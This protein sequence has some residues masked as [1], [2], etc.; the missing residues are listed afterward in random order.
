MRTVTTRRRA[1]SVVAFT[2]MA[3]GAATMVVPFL[4]MVST[5]LKDKSVVFRYPPQWIPSPAQ[6]QNFVDIWS[7]MPL[8]RGLANSVIV[9]GSVVVIGLFTSTLAAFA[10]ATLDL[11]HKELLFTVVL[12]IMM[13]PAITVIIPQFLLYSEIG[14]IDTLWPLIVP[15]ALG[16]AAMI[17]FLRQFI[18][19]LPSELMDAARVDGASVPRTYWTIYLPLLKPAMAAYVIIV[20]MWTWNQYLEPL[21]FT[22]SPNKQT[23]Q[24]A[25]AAL[26]SYYREQTNFPIVMAASVIA[27]LP[28]IIMFVI[29]QRY[30]IDS[31]AIS[32][33]KG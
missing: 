4:W 32:G 19:G 30:F 14:W 10:F 12:I 6:W 20:F 27:I 23:V 17:F 11:P 31:F 13:F 18:A 28:V 33:F 29:L 24:L 15:G 21:I 3:L 1:A 16:N 5:A 26:V 8:A 9:S 2:L 25:I 22:H 7:I